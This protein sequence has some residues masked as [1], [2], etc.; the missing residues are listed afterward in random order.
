MPVEFVHLGGR[1]DYSTE[2][3]I[4]SP[5]QLVRAAAGNGQKAL[6]LADMETLA[7]AVE[8]EAAARRL[9]IRPLFGL[10]VTISGNERPQKLRLLARNRAG[11]SH[12]VTLSSHC[13]LG[14]KKQ[15]IDDATFFQA[16]DGLFVLVNTDSAVA[17]SALSGDFE[18]A[19]SEMNSLMQSFGRRNIA[20][21]LEPPIDED[22]RRR[23]VLLRKVARHFGIR[24]V[25]VPQIHC[26]RAEDDLAWCLQSG[27]HNSES[28]RTFGDLAR[29]HSFRSHVLS[30]EEISDLY[31]DFPE[32]V[33]STV[34]I[35]ELCQ[36]RLPRPQKIFPRHEFTRGVDADSFVWNKCFER[37]AERYG[38]GGI[39][40]WQERLNREFEEL[41]RLG[42]A[43]A[44][45][46]LALLDEALEEK[47][48]PRG[49]GAGFLTNSLVASLLGLTRIDPMRFDLPFLPPAESAEASPVLELAIP[50]SRSRDAEK[51]LEELFEKGLCRGGKW[52][53]RSAG[54]AT[55][56]VADRL[57]LDIQRIRRITGTAAWQRAREEETLGPAGHDPDHTL[58]LSDVRSIAW[59]VRRFEG[60]VRSPRP[61]DGEF[62]LVA[63]DGEAPLPRLRTND[64][65]ICCQW[66]SDACTGLGFARF[67]FVSRPLLDLMTE[68]AGWIRE[69]GSRHYD[70]TLIGGE[71]K[72]AAE[73][74]SSGFTQGIL[75][76]EPPSLRRA[77]RQAAPGTLASLSR[78]C[79]EQDGRSITGFETTL[80]AWTCAGMKS[81]EPAAFLAAAL[82][83]FA[84]EPGLVAALLADARRL[85][86]EIL[87]IDLNSSAERWAPDRS[88]GGPGLR[89][90]L[91]LIKGL[92][93]TA[94]REI[95]AVRREMTYSNLADLLRRTHPQLVKLN[96]VELLIRAGALDSLGFSRQDL[97]LQLEELAPLLRPTGRRKAADDPLEFFGQDG[98]W[99]LNNQISEDVFEPSG[100]GDSLEWIVEQE[101]KVMGHVISLNPFYFEDE[102][103]SDARIV[104][105]SR[106]SRKTVDGE[107][108]IVGFIGSM[109]EIDDGGAPK[110]LIEMEGCLIEAKPVHA[111]FLE[112]RFKTGQ[113]ILAAGRLEREGE[114]RL[115]H[116]DILES[117]EEAARRALRAESVEI[118]VPRLDTDE[119]KTLY[120]LLKRYPGSTP[121]R[122][123][124]VPEDPKR[125]YGK[126][127]SRRVNLCPGLEL[128]LNRIA[129]TRCWRAYVSAGRTSSTVKKSKI[130][131]SLV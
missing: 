16:R 90:G 130:H 49:P 44:L 116:A 61:V 36:V 126:L 13:A 4:A 29:D 19:E 110:I 119:L 95:V 87:P 109:E 112:R 22:A 128:G 72:G 89:P 118:D 122:V 5:E 113:A 62:L 129:G 9:G 65:E 57:G 47:E 50:S 114:I 8:F 68:A 86:L 12:L 103:L 18:Q 108:A 35:A 26:S 75:R 115:L 58:S 125:I 15:P 6:A 52:Q 111:S 69:Q 131:Q 48:I 64:D 21:V 85:S 78:I 28:P 81:A 23:C 42:L 34:E 37:A 55:E 88:G 66:E 14:Q 27:L 91:I 94:I 24:A 40:R 10:E 11:W 71:D 77:L 60:R 127:R 31:A 102:W 1:S 70:P 82:S 80:L 32:A 38:E 30:G 53:R 39:V 83:E 121:V 74:V 120:A 97:L 46:T 43:D 93:R 96:H 2:L 101:L 41:S 117:P 7:G 92:T 54:A 105:A 33:A 20:V 56:I 73:T 98:S 59:L 17:R 79:A 25:A 63:P 100:D 123:T 124:G 99:W 45:V 106:V 104:S 67:R 107:T 3:S 51:A 76:L 84:N